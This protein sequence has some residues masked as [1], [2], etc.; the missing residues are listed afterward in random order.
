VGLGPG[1]KKS[2]LMLT[3]CFY[4]SQ[5]DDISEFCSKMSLLWRD[6]QIGC[7]GV[8]WSKKSPSDR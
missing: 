4:F 1:L 8:L 3:P 2:V 6:W 5:F 7:G